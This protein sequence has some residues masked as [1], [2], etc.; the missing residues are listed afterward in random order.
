MGIKA[1]ILYDYNLMSLRYWQKNKILMEPL[2]SNKTGISHNPGMVICMCDGRFRSGGL[3]DRLH[4]ILSLYTFCNANNIPYK[5][6]FCEPFRLKEYLEPNEVDWDIEPNE[7]CYDL[8]GAKPML[9]ACSSRNNGASVAQEAK[10]MYRYL[11]SKI[12]KGYNKEYHIYTNMHY[13]CRPDLYSNLFHKL[14]KLSK[15]L[16][17]AIDWNKDQIGSKYVSVTLRFQNLLGDF[18][19][20][21]FPTLSENKQYELICK[22]QSKIQMLHKEYH[23]NMK[24]LITS[25]SRKFLD[26]IDK[27]DWCYTIPG[28]L[29]HMS[30]TPVHDFNTHLKSFVDLLMLSEAE[31]LYLLVTDDMYK[32][33]FA[34]SAA[35]INNRP[36]EFIFF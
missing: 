25:D 17:E 24:F 9:M 21:N 27:E 12:K 36:Y 22:V 29:V 5:V 30:Y 15:P 13:V 35:F 4:G 18:K 14:F 23:P 16:K 28:K 2:Y 20:G 6:N 1:K 3:A 8:H 10:F 32:S 19:E 7:L 34:E 26:V 33:G 31:K 11:E